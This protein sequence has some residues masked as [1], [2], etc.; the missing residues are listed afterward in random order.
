VYLHQEVDLNDHLYSYGYT[1]QYPD[2]DSATFTYEGP[3]DEQQTLLKLKAGQARP[4]LSG[5]PLLN[6]RTGGVCGIVKSTRD[7][8]SDLGGRAVPTS[9]ILLLLS[10][11]VALQQR[12]HQQDT[13]WMD[14]LNLEQRQRVPWRTVYTH[15]PFY[16]ESQQLLGRTQE[17]QRIWGKL[18][19]GNH[20][21]IVGPHGSGKSRLLKELREQMW[22]QLGW[23]VQEVFSISLRG[24]IGLRELQEAVVVYLGG[25]KANELRSLLRYKP[26]RLLMLDDLGGMDPGKRGLDMRRWLRGLDDLC[27]TKLLMVSNERLDILFRKDD[28]TRDSPLA[29]LDPLPVQLAPL[30]SDVCRQ[31]VQQRLA[32]TSFDVTQFADLLREP[33]QPKELLDM[34]VARYETLRQGNP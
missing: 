29:G 24:I 30:P 2:G 11:L 5:A 22:V 18:R 7:R 1:D 8:D 25:Q 17:I 19:A 23:P 31:I 15:N 20:C 32:G 16:G 13:R 6:L 10:D 12:F 33:R 4:G 34:C 3:T 9:V 14:C 27:G 21:S 26:L 28:P